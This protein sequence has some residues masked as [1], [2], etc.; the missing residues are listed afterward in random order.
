MFLHLR[1]AAADFLDIVEQHKGMSVG[2]LLLLLWGWHLRGMQKPN[3]CW[4]PAGNRC[5]LS[6]AAG[7]RAATD[8]AG[9]TST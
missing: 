4:R 8:T 3:S 7:R 1:A 5:L 6:A 9:I 2:W